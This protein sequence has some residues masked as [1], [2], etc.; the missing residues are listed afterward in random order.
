VALRRAREDAAREVQCR[1]L[2]HREDIV[3]APG[4]V[5]AAPERRGGQVSPGRGQH[6]NGYRSLRAE[7]L[8]TLAKSTRNTDGSMLKVHIEPKW[9]SVGI[10]DVRPMAVEEVHHRLLL[11]GGG[12]RNIDDYLGALQY[13]SKS[14]TSERVHARVR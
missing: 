2:S 8:P 14:L 7:Y 1:R 10:A 9:G 11:R 3:E 12:V 4:D 6:G 5:G 13:F